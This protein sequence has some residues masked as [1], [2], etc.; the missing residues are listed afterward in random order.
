MPFLERW[1]FWDTWPSFAVYA[2]HNERSEVYVW[3]VDLPRLPETIRRHAY[4][5][6]ETRWS[7]IDLTGWSRAERGVPPYPQSRTES[8]VGEWLATRFRLVH[9]VRV[10][11]RTSGRPL[12]RAIGPRPSPSAPGK[13]GSGTTDSGST[14]IPPGPRRPEARWG[15]GTEDAK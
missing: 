10:V 6:E 1:G 7:R 2:S 3:N 15:F 12:D 4:R 5:D 9:E 13:P 14:P 8:A 11:H